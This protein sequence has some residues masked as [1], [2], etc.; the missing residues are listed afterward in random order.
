MRGRNGWM[1]LKESDWK[2]EEGKVAE[3]LGGRRAT[4]NSFLSLPLLL[5]FPRS[6][7]FLHLRPAPL[8]H[9][10]NEKPRNECTFPRYTV[11]SS[12]LPPSWIIFHLR[13]HVLH[14][15]RPF[16]FSFRRD[17]FQLRI[18]RKVYTGGWKYVVNNIIP[19][20]VDIDNY[21]EIW[22]LCIE[23]LICVWIKF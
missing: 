22:I 15:I 12:W 21:K 20:I 1:V 5:T 18:D 3:S 17:R 16:Y 14:Y 23:E 11:P 4:R 6:S 13:G 7:F 8:I 10:R 9:S 2:R 19:E